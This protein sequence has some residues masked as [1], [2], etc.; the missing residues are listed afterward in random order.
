[1]SLNTQKCILQLFLMID[2]IFVWFGKYKEKKKKEK[3]NDGIHLFVFLIHIFALFPSCHA[4]RVAI[5][6]VCR[7]VDTTKP[8]LVNM[9]FFR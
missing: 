1:M 7:K 3:F 5:R 6:Y 4:P 2:D 9:H 8:S